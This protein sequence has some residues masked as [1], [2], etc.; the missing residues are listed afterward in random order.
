MTAAQGPGRDWTPEAIAALVDGAVTDAAEADRLRRIVASDPEAAAHAEAV[1]AMNALLAEA[2]PLPEAEPVPAGIAAALQADPGKLAVLRPRRPAAFLPMAMAASVA[3]AVGL[4]T[5]L[6][7]APDRAGGP[8]LVGLHQPGDPHHA[9]LETLASG[10]VS[11]R[12]LRPLLSFVDGAGRPC[13][14]FELAPG[15]TAKGGG[16]EAAGIACRTG[17]GWE[18]SVLVAVAPPPEQGA[19]FA[20][21]SGPATGVLDAALDALGAGAAL[22]PDAEA[23]LIGRGWRDLPPG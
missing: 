15:G 21:A 11:D 6:L 16:A 8:V 2:F 22:A 19:E 5:G 18:V 14:E 17:A 1:G 3:L 20:P 13:R 23:A 12:G 4:G 9:A 7:L 10:A